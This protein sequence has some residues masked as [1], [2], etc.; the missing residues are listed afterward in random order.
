MRRL[1]IVVLLSAAS[2]ATAALAGGTDGAGTRVAV[3]GGISV[4]LPRGWHVRRG[5]L[6]DVVDPIPRLAVA[7][8]PVR[9][10]RHTCECGM[11]NVRDFPRAGAFLFVWEYARLDAAQLRRF[12]RRPARFRVAQGNAHWGECA[13]PSWGTVFRVSG[14]GFQV[15]VYL[16]PAADDKVRARMDGILSSLEVTRQGPR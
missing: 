9:L 7:S 11:P 8:F 16:G 15:E 2:L 12:P 4:R 10:S 1:G 14:R 5:W 3:G 6:S 13:G